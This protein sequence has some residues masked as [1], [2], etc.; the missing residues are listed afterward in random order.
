MSR[1]TLIALALLALLALPRAAWAGGVVVSLDGTPTDVQAGAPFTV[2]FVIRSMHDGQAMNGLEPVVRAR[3]TSPASTGVRVAALGGPQADVV[4]DIPAAPAAKGEEVSV[5]ATQQG[6]VGH[7]VA[8][9]TL[10]AAGVWE[11]EIQPLGVGEPN[12]PVSKLSPLQVRAAGAQAAPAGAA[13]P[14][15]VTLPVLAL[16]ALGAVI[17]IAALVLLRTRRRAVVRP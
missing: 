4:A 15:P 11:W 12:Y 10:P 1:R 8:T 6:E 2:G 17:V 16:A 5:V 7:Y 9:L 14:A 3:L 13:Q